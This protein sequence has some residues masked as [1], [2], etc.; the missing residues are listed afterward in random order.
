MNKQ[1]TQL[2]ITKL[3]NNA[4]NLRYGSASV[5]VKLHDGRVVQVTYSTQE[6]TR[7][8]NPNKDSSE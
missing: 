2:M 1:K 6:H 4:A 3:M 5:T 8:Q 7:E